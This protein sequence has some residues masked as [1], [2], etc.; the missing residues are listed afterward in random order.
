MTKL[1]PSGN[2]RSKVAAALDAGLEGIIVKRSDSI[3]ERGGG[4]DS[5][6]KHRINLSPEF[7][8][9]GY[10]PSHLRI[11]SIVIGVYRGIEPRYV[12]RVRAGFVPLARRQVFERIKRLETAKCPFRN[13]PEKDAGHG[14]QGLTAEKMRSG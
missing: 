1:L 3:Y 7:V 14:E 4:A 5:G 6:Q 11:D 12:A 13:L 8:I 2:K 10:V 9:G